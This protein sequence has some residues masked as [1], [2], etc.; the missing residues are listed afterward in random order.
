MRRAQLDSL[1]FVV[2]R[3]DHNNCLCTGIA[4]EVLHQIAVTLLRGRLSCSNIHVVTSQRQLTRLLR[5][6]VDMT[7]SIHGVVT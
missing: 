6:N 4:G 7:Y 2:H 3:A 5:V 1:M